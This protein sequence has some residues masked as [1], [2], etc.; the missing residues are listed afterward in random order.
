ME[1]TSQNKNSATITTKLILHR[2]PFISR[3]NENT[4]RTPRT[5]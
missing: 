3:R 2:V 1:N 4:N 5:S